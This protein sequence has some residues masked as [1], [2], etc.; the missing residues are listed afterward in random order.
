MYIH[1]ISH[2][3]D[4]YK[5][6]LKYKKLPEEKYQRYLLK[7]TDIESGQRELN[8]ITNKTTKTHYVFRW[9]DQNLTDERQIK[10]I[11]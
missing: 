4:L 11:L 5:D 6:I 3:T 9:G 1:P 10:T 7:L 8:N 2:F